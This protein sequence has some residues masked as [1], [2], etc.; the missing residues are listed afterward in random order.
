MAD[1]DRDPQNAEINK[2]LDEIIADLKKLFKQKDEQEE[3]KR[4]AVLAEKAP[5]QP[6]V[7]A[8]PI[9]GPPQED[10]ARLWAKEGAQF[11]RAAKG[12]PPLHFADEEERRERVTKRARE[13]KKRIIIRRQP[14]EGLLRP[15]GLPPQNPQD[16]FQ[17]LLDA[18]T[19]LIVD[20]L[21]EVIK[22]NAGCGP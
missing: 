16:Q 14:P 6:A 13:R 20:K 2:K 4:V 21:I 22:Q 19:A 10:R 8:K 11:D 9:E 18:Q 3:R 12:L 17:K 15:P 7:P 5:T 1:V